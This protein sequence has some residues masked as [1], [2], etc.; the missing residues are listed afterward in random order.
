[1]TANINSNPV[2]FLN[3]LHDLIEKV[4][5]NMPYYGDKDKKYMCVCSDKIPIDMINQLRLFSNLTVKPIDSNI[6]PDKN[7]IYFIPDEPI[8]YNFSN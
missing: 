4:S 7:A 6:M 3:D 1:M 8:K 5:E 2:N